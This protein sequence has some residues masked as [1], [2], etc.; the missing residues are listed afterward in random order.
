M[1][2]ICSGFLCNSSETKMIAN[3]YSV[4]NNLID[5]CM[6]GPSITATILGSVLAKSHTTTSACDIFSTHFINMK[7][8]S[9]EGSKMDRTHFGRKLCSS[10]RRSFD[11]IREGRTIFNVERKHHY[12]VEPSTI[13]TGKIFLKG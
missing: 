11:M 2:L 6:H 12:C 9:I 1:I 10:F 7:M 4:Q 3:L 13:V 8:S 5:L